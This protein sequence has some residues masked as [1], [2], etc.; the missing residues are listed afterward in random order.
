MHGL[1][2]LGSAGRSQSLQAFRANSNLSALFSAEIVAEVCPMSTL[3]VRTRRHPTSKAAVISHEA[4]SVGCTVA[5]ISVGG[6]RLLV[7]RPEAVPDQF[8]LTTDLSSS[9]RQCRT[10]W[11]EDG[12]VGIEFV[13]WL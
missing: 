10:I 3:R 1:R 8:E 6:A 9:P 12:E 4:W 13:D 5:D 11:R 2:A 7:A